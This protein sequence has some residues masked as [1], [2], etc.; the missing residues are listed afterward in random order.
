MAPWA[1]ACGRAEQEDTAPD[2]QSL[3]PDVPAFS[4]RDL[5]F[6]IKFCEEFRGDCF[7]ALVRALCPAI[8][9]HELIK[10]RGALCDSPLPTCHACR[11]PAPAAATAA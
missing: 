11:E 3:A 9:G 4:G 5:R 6:I 8:Y 7:R 2:E 10:V 1:G